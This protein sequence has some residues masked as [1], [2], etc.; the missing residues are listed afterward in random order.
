MTLT[1]YIKKLQK[2]EAAGYGKCKLVQHDYSGE[3]KTLNQRI[4]VPK[5]GC[6]MGGL[7][8]DKS[9]MKEYKMKDEINAI[10]LN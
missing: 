3:W 1:K 2:F 9:L 8:W 7:F 5:L 10:C 4:G 6:L